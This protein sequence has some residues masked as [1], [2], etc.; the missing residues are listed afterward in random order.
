MQQRLN[1]IINGQKVMGIVGETIL[2]L[3]RRHQ[4]D[5]PTL[6]HD[7][8]LK[9]Y[10]SCF[11]CVV[12]VEGMRGMQPSC[13]TRIAEGMIIE[14]DNEKVH[15]ARKMALDLLVSDHYA[16]CVAPCRQTC[17]AGVD[18]QGYIAMMEKGKYRDAVAIIK[19]T[20]PLPA[21]CGRVC[22]RPCEVACRRNQL[23][24][25]SPVGIDYLKRYAADE[26][27]MSGDPWMPE[28]AP[29]TGKK[30]AVIG[31][32]PGGL[33]AAFFIQKAGHQVDVLEA[34]T[35]G[36]GWLRYGIPQY[37]LPNEVL[38]QEIDN[39][40]RMGVKF[41]YHHKL[42][43]NVDFASLRKKYDA[44]V[45]AIGAQTGTRIGCE[46]D[47]A[48]NVM[49]GI[50]YLKEMEVT[51]TRADFSGKRVAVVGG[52]N[53]AMD[54]CRSA[55]RCNAQKVY[56]IYRRTEKE[57]PA[58][59]IEIHESKLE[60]VEYLFL[61]NPVRVNKDAEN[62][63][64][65]ITCV[66]MAL[67]APDASGRRRPVP[68]EG[69]EFELELDVVLAAI[70][71]KV[72][73]D[74]LEQINHHNPLGELELNRWGTLMADEVTQQTGVKNIFACGDGVTGPATLIQAV[75]AGRRAAYSVN[76]YLLGHEVK[77]QPQEFLS[78]R[79][80]FREQ[81]PDDYQ[82]QYVVQQREEM[83]VLEVSQRNNF[84]EVEQGY[85]NSDVVKHETQRCMECGCSEYYTC[86]LKKYA[87]QYQAVQNKFRGQ[88][89]EYPVDFRHP[90]IE[91]DNNKCILCSRCIRI[92]DE[93]VGAK[94]LGLVNRGFDT[95]VAPAMGNKLS[96][97]PCESCGLCISACPTGAITENYPF[98]PGPV[99]TEIVETVCNYCSV[100]CTIQYHHRTGYVMKVTGG[101]GMVNTQG[102]LC[103]MAK[104]GYRFINHARRITTPMVRYHN[105]DFVPISWDGAMKL[106]VKNIRE[107]APQHTALFAGA[108]LSN[109]AL[110]LLQKLARVAI[111]TNNIDSFSN[112]GGILG[113]HKASE[114]NMPLHALDKV[115]H[116]WLI[117][118]EISQHHA[119]AGFMVYNAAHEQGTEV[120][121]ITTQVK[122]H[123][124][125]KCNSV[126]HI[127]SYYHFL[128]AVNHYIVSNRLQNDVYLNDHVSHYQGYKSALLSHDFDTLLQQAGITDLTVIMRFVRSYNRSLTGVAIGSVQELSGA[129]VQE[130]INMA[131][132]TGKMGKRLGGVIILHEKNNS[133]GLFDM[134]I[135]STLAPGG[136][137]MQNP[138]VH[139][140]LAATWGVDS[141][142]HRDVNLLTM[143]DEGALKNL[144]IFG[145]DPLGCDTTQRAGSWLHQTG[146]VVVQDYF[147][148]PTAQHAH[149]VLP[150]TLPAETGGSF[151]NTQK[152]IQACEAVM[153]PRVEMNNLEQIAAI[154]QKLGVDSPSSPHDIMSEVARILPHNPPAGPLLQDPPCDGIPRLFTHGCDA[155]Q[156]M[157]EAEFNHA[158]DH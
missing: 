110:Y 120:H 52:G 90:Y 23:D 153:P 37:R 7:P 24:E 45:L 56:V 100:G 55:I 33:S 44:F 130:L 118:S 64:Q 60:G 96:D 6:C 154:M 61:T 137:D 148:T 119:V 143:L 19:E 34:A 107:Q 18:V 4:I 75:G 77:P 11:V 106:I 10:T 51:G 157:F 138:E 87:T 105:G 101:Q 128:K 136:S 113:Y 31:A 15:R 72:V 99:K 94:A 70:G 74:F 48:L 3:A 63:M 1:I 71:Q 69:S 88:H 102:N 122:S 67:G 133:Q 65:S 92:C 98:K 84:N 129:A 26:D 17:P 114:N 156:R 21:I 121:Q 14:T 152:M 57:M 91:I 127:K 38:Q 41:H 109:E 116:I 150:A 142:P 28:I 16:D 42:G 36:G 112:L 144:F 117:G 47:D 66:K 132:L 139:Q 124:E 58:N 68:I 30:V 108:R 135:H 86:D 78:R 85:H 35:Q 54:C 62:I 43:D 20:N 25:E 5:I 151:T 103:R 80:N 158:F 147:M 126:L 49:P 8:R 123:E 93:V 76:Q 140:Q 39:I 104:F 145:E 27:L 79:D 12:Q 46:G 22:V 111:K 125:H 40:A 53:T 115:Q 146:F 155:I 131:I 50:D 134:G 95:F 82:H 97:T 149:L 83:P 29:A 2:D 89:N 73:V 13:S 59:P 81:Q 32:G 141:V 9:P